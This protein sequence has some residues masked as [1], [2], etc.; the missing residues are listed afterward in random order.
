[1]ARNN[2]KNAIQINIK[3]SFGETLFY[4]RKIWIFENVEVFV[5]LIMYV[6]VVGVFGA[7][8]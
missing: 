8:Y 7:I 3:R 4:F 2:I 1:M 5:K 6:R